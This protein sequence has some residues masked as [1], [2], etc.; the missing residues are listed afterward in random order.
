MSR[1]DPTEVEAHCVGLARAWSKAVR[2]LGL[3]PALAEQQSHIAVAELPRPVAGLVEK[4]ENAGI[5]ASAAGRRLRI[6]VHYFNT[7]DDIDRMIRI[8]RDITQDNT[9]A[10]K[11]TIRASAANQQGGR[12]TA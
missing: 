6:G 4:L 1:L 3:T 8:L 12:C 10:H 11:P 9:E 5:K 7:K 2:E